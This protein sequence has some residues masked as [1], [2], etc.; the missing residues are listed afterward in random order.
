M[1]ELAYAS[2][3]LRK[4]AYLAG[5]VDLRHVHVS[6]SISLFEPSIR[7]LALPKNRIAVLRSLHQSYC[8]LRWPKTQQEPSK[9]SIPLLRGDCTWYFAYAAKA[10]RSIG[11]R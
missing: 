11:R 9:Y 1:G 4:P 7:S 10:T 2:L 6:L 3:T 8:I 5:R